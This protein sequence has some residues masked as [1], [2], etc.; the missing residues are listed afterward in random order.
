MHILTCCVL[1]YQNGGHLT[2]VDCQLVYTSHVV[3]TGN[4]MESC[5]GKFGLKIIGEMENNQSITKFIAQQRNAIRKGAHKARD[6]S[7]RLCILNLYC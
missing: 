1:L 3:N 6:Q 7:Y 2:N 5:F 4:D